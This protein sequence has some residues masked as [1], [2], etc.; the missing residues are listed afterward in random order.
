MVDP[1]KL[2]S[3]LEC[4]LRPVCCALCVVCCVLC[5]ANE[6]RPIR[7]LFIRNGGVRAC[8]RACNHCPPVRVCGGTSPRLYA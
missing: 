6:T 1:S 3:F 8:V 5:V 2:R 7:L 4:V